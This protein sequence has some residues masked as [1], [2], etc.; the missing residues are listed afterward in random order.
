MLFKLVSLIRKEP[1]IV[2]PL[3]VWILSSHVASIFFPSFFKTPFQLN[4]VILALLCIQFFATLLTIFLVSN[5]YMGHAIRLNEFMEILRRSKLTFLLT[6]IVIECLPKVYMHF[7][8]GGIELNLES[9]TLPELLLESSIVWL[10]ISVSLL[11][12]KQFLIIQERSF[13][14][15]IRFSVRF[16]FSRL[17]KL[18]FLLLFIV[19]I[20]FILGIFWSILLSGPSVFKT[21]G[22]LVQG[23]MI[24]IVQGVLTIFFLD[25]HK[26][27]LVDIVVED[28]LTKDPLI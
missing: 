25:E 24:T 18:I 2:A 13:F 27:Q 17:T 23:L 3:M 9:E 5:T 19:S 1:V 7:M 14:Q 11:F 16:V 28:N 22:V 21:L 8:F 6:L 12:F 15:S 10:I 4:V 26:P 20:M